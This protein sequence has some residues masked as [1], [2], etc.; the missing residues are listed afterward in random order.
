MPETLYLSPVHHQSK[1]QRLNQVFLSSDPADLTKPNV[2]INRSVIFERQ[3]QIGFQLIVLHCYARRVSDI[4]LYQLGRARR[5]GRGARD[6]GLHLDLERKHGERL[7]HHLGDGV[8]QV[9]G[10]SAIELI[11]EDRKADILRGLPD[12][13]IQDKVIIG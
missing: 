12:D 7:G 3:S 10:V 6:A 2:Q 4:T 9:L 11:L 1:L 8:R 13:A 5:G